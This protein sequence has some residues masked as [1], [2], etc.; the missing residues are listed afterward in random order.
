M[1]SLR[2]NRGGARSDLGN[3]LLL[4]GDAPA[5]LAEMEQEKSEIRRMIGPPMAY[6]CA[7][8]RKTDADAALNALI[9]KYEKDASYNVAYVYAFCGD[10][11]KAFEWLVATVVA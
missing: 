7:L 11:D 3:A 2:P 1:L 5:A 6:Y 10:A 9:A 4:K 8:G